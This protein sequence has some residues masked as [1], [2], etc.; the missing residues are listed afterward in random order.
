M[1]NGRT[2][3]AHG[4]SLAAI[5][6][7]MVALSKE[8]YGKGP[9]SARTYHLGDLV[10]VLLRGGY[11]PAEQALLQEGHTKAVLEQRA[12]LHEVM[13]PRLKQVVE[14]ELRRGVC[15][16]MNTMHHDPDV[17]A[18]LFLLEPHGFEETIE[19]ADGAAPR[20]AAG[21]GRTLASEG[22]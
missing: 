12:A 8:Y 22:H 18:E 2:Q 10:V 3:S 15:A 5:S 20:R 17:N 13:R 4:S 16:F 11:T 6:R 19:S 21:D 9:T 14:E 1:S 7:R